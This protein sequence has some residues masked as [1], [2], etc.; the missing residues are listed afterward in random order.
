MND[1][2]A[3]QVQDLHKRFGDIQAVQGISFDV[4]AGRDL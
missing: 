1:H 3:I 4:Q 2:Q